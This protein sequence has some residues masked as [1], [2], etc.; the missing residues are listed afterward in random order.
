MVEFTVPGPPVAA[1]RAR[2]ARVGNH[3]RTYAPKGNVDYTARVRDAF[4]RQID[5]EALAAA[6]F[7]RG[8]PLQIEATFYF[9]RPKGHFGTGRNADKLKASAPKWHT[10]KP[11]VD[12]CLKLLKDALKGLAWHDDSQ[13]AR[14]GQV[15]KLYVENNPRTELRISAIDN[16]P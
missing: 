11:D 5:D 6:P 2:F 12:N 13:I 14:Y 1:A 3:V 16:H 15:E 9:P 7:P 4:L 10:T 8:V